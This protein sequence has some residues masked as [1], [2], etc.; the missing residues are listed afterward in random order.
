MPAAGMARLPE[1]TIKAVVEVMAAVQNY[2]LL[3]ALPLSQPALLCFD[4]KGG[5]SSH[6]PPLPLRVKW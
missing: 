1:A 2:G 6:F 4:E 5:I 3:L